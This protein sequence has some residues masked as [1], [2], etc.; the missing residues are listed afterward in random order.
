M[1]IA[2]QKEEE[3]WKGALVLLERTLSLF[4]PV[5]DPPFRPKPLEKKLEK[6]NMA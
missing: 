1:D 3:T 2:I 5:C 4:Q 6:N